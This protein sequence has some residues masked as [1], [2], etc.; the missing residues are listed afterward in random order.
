MRHHTAKGQRKSSAASS[1]ECLDLWP[2]G[3]LTPSC[4][5]TSHVARSLRGSFGTLKTPWQ[6]WGKSRRRR[7]D[8]DLADGGTFQHEEEEEEECGGQGGHPKSIHHPDLESSPPLVVCFSTKFNY[9]DKEVT[10]GVTSDEWDG[11]EMMTIIEEMKEKRNR[12]LSS[13]EPW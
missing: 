12:A 6:I 8:V 3:A 9:Q 4:R 7:R 11:K 13:W 10:P 1:A 2:L 5:L